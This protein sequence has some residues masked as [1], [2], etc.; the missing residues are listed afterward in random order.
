MTFLVAMMPSDVPVQLSQ[1]WPEEFT[2]QSEREVKDFIELAKECGA[3]GFIKEEVPMK[4]EDSGVNLGHQSGAGTPIRESGA[5][6]DRQRE[7]A[8]HALGFPNKRGRSYRNHYCIG[9]DEDGY[10]A[11]LDLV[12]KGLAHWRPYRNSNGAGVGFHMFYLTHRG[13]LLARQ[14]N[15]HLSPEDAA[16]M[17][18]RDAR[19]ERAQPEKG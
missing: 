13:A 12:T 6:S 1:E 14:P 9:P 18:E 11:W 16:T 2:P 4:P 19:A 8:R 3:W 5:M 15:E 10:D 7:M 17:R